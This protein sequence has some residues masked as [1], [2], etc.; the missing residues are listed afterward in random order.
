MNK[1]EIGV[2]ILQSCLLV[3]PVYE[4]IRMNAFIHICAQ[5]YGDGQGIPRASYIG[6][7]VP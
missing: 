3:G 1:L 4:T 5:I 7:K 6:K 2:I